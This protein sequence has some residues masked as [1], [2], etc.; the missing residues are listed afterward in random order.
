MTM[1]PIGHQR[2][3]WADVR[4]ARR[5]SVL[6]AARPPSMTAAICLILSCGSPASSPHLRDIYAVLKRLKNTLDG[7][8]MP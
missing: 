5:A 1:L 6:G 3:L 2:H 7:N 8:I 4:P